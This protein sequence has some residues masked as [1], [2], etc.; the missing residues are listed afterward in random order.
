MCGYVCQK[1][2]TTYG[3]R[4]WTVWYTPDIP[5]SA[6]PW[7]FQGL[8]GLI[9]AANDSEG[10]FSFNAITFRSGDTPITL[11]D[12]LKTH[13][14]SRDKVLKHKVY[15]EEKGMNGIDPSMI[16]R[17]DVAKTLNGK[18]NIIINGVSMRERSNPYIPLEKQ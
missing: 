6:G 4:E 8:P 15:V 2:T 12:K 9:M 14:S 16:E 7:K 17:I 11:P 18:P 10:I 1:A 3:G 13:Y 5:V